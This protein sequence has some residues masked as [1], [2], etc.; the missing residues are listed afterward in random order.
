MSSGTQKGAQIR[1]SG[2]DQER[3]LETNLRVEK[4]RIFALMSFRAIS[5]GI[6]GAHDGGGGML[7]GTGRALTFLLGVP[8]LGRTPPSAAGP[9]SGRRCRAA[10]A[11][12]PV[13]QRS[14]RRCRRQ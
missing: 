14:G 11:A 9:R 6:G 12:P 2:G 10:R 1:V 5:G 3:V 8:R 7:A 4:G 13:A